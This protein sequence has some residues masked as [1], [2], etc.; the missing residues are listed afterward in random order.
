MATI[1]P[2]RLDPD[3][4]HVVPV[5]EI[6]RAGETPSASSKG[7]LR[8]SR[9]AGVTFQ[10]QLLRTGII[11]LPEAPAVARGGAGSVHAMSYEPEWFARTADGHQVRLYSTD[12]Q[13]TT[14]YTSKWRIDRGSDFESSKSV[15]GTACF[16]E[17]GLQRDNP[18]A[19]WHETATSPRLFSPGWE[20]TRWPVQEVYKFTIGDTEFTRTRGSFRFGGAADTVLTGAQR[21][22]KSGTWLSYRDG[23]LENPLWFP[24]SCDRIRGLFSILTGQHAVFA[25]RDIPDSSNSLTRL[26]YGWHRGID[27]EHPVT[28]P[29]PLCR[30]P[31]ALVHGAEVVERLSELERRYSELSDLLDPEFIVA[32]LWAAEKD[33]IENKLALGCVAL[34]RLSAAHYRHFRSAGIYA[35]EPERFSA[36]QRKVL[37]S[38]MRQ[39]LSEVA[40]T[41]QLTE[42][43]TRSAA[44]K[45]NQL[46]DRSNSE[47]LKLPFKELGVVLS[48]MDEKAIRERNLAMH[49]NKTSKAS[50]GS[51][52]WK[53]EL[54]AYDVLRTL[55]GRALLHMLG[56]DGPYVDYGARPELGHYPICFCKPPARMPKTEM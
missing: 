48:D 11:L 2:P 9:K 27:P 56:Y 42:E 37:I 13:P 10:F 45:L 28:Q 5:A 1:D 20:L 30:T 38:R 22:G 54:H 26:Y 14:S 6:H 17:V 24:K 34:E 49:G 46:C 21:D 25:W 35:T 4:T 36:E 12:F 52:E 41:E 23:D 19:F 32:P 16:A 47:K 51:G 15:E 3:G 55:I 53:D 43:A 33:L 39:L 7:E 50:G 31:L 8:W 18:L 40:S 29:V 44:N